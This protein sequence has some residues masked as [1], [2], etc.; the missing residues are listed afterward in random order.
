MENAMHNDDMLNKLG[1]H[2]CH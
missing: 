2:A 1:L